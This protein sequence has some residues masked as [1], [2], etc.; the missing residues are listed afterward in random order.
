VKFPSATRRNVY[1]RSQRAGSRVMASITRF[2]ERKLRLKVNRDK[3]AVARPEERHFLGFRL[4]RKPENGEAEVLLSKRSKERIAE[5]IRELTPRNWGKSLEECTKRLKVYLIGWIGF[6][7]MCTDAEERVFSN[8]DA[9]IRRR[10]RAIVLKH[11][12]RKQYIVRNLIRM[13]VK[14]KTAWRNIYKGKQSLW[15]LSHN[16]AVERGLRNAYFAERGLVSILEQ[17]RIKSTKRVIAPVQLQLKL[18]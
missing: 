4:R 7:W 9:H 5:K 3:S 17:W 15:A 2:I 6:F 8:I 11:W 13:G 14:P 12:K 1:V 18:G 10:L 16:T